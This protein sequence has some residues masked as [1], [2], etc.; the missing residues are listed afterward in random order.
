LVQAAQVETALVMEATAQSQ[1]LVIY[2]LRLG[3]VEEHRMVAVAIAATLLHKVLYILEI[4][5]QAQ[6]G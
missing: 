1:S 4:L 5:A 3:V 2:L 6:T